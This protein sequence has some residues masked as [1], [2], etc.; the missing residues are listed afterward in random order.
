MVYRK[1]GPACVS[2]RAGCDSR[3]QDR[4]NK[5]GRC[6]GSHL[7]RTAR[8]RH[9]RDLSAHRCS[10]TSFGKH[11]AVVTDARFS[12][13]STGACIG[14][15]SPEALAGG[16]LGKLVAG[17]VIEIVIDRNTL[18]GR[19]NFVGS[20]DQ[21]VSAEEGSRVLAARP[22]RK[23]LAPDPLLPDDI[24]GAALQEVSGGTWG[25]RPTM[26]NQYSRCS[27][28]VSVRSRKLILYLEPGVFD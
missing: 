13:V 25:G 20:N 10:K 19:V 8:R 28:Q 4:R 7:P 14:H 15:I 22:P 21:R 11:V 17:D 18:E 2:H 1:V 24:L 16:P 9:G 26:S 3:D 27:M 12:G 6:P 5:V 23:D